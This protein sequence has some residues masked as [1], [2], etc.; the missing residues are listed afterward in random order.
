MLPHHIITAVHFLILDVA[1]RLET[2][3]PRVIGAAIFT[4]TIENGDVE[5]QLDATVLGPGATAASLLPW[6]DDRLD[7]R[8]TLTGYGLSHSA[9][10]LARSSHGVMPSITEALAGRGRHP[11]IELAPARVGGDP[12]TFAA[13]CLQAGLPCSVPQG[14][15]DFLAWLLKHPVPL[16]HQLEIDVISVWRLAM[17][18]IG[19]TTA[20]GR[21]IGSVIDAHLIDWLKITDF[22]AG[23]IHLDNLSP[24]DG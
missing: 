13:T 19:A 6:L 12:A 14:S 3:S 9:S 8:A 5:F 23:A 15:H 16:I 2:P 7:P 18:R 24:T 11:I 22:P 10:L 20:L 1:H 4:G 21:R 17:A